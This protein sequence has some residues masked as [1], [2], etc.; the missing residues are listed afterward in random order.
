MAAKLTIIR[1][2][3]RRWDWKETRSIVRRL[4]LPYQLMVN[5]T[6]EASRARSNVTI[7]EIS[8]IK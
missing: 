2:V 3:M 6:F 4:V 7:E 8:A 1:A 5:I